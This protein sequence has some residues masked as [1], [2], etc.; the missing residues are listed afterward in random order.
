MS[1]F[2]EITDA[3]KAAKELVA[4]VWPSRDK[5]KPLVRQHFFVDSNGRHQCVYCRV[6]HTEQSAKARCTYFT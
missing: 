5:P 2:S 3:L 1:I 6:A 4:T